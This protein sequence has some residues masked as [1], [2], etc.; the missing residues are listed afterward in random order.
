MEVAPVRPTFGFFLRVFGVAF[1]LGTVVGLLLT[2][3]IGERAAGAV[4]L[5]LMLAIV[6][7]ASPDWRQRPIRPY[8]IHGAFILVLSF[9]AEYL[10][11]P[12]FR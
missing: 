3:L 8:L 2:P 9:L 10:L 5:A 12:Y 6:F 7:L 4:R 1:L 11:M